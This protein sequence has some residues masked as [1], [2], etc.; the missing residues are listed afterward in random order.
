M[1]TFYL[2]ILLFYYTSQIND[3]NT[4][5]AVAAAAAAAAADFIDL[6]IIDEQ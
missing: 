3:L 6:N 4:A 5:A 2:R 1:K